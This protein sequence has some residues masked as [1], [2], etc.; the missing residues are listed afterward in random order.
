[1]LIT[2]GALRINNLSLFSQLGAFALNSMPEHWS[3]AISDIITTLQNA[4]ASS[5]QVNSNN[6]STCIFSSLVTIYALQ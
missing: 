1:M 5:S 6:R 3:N 4:A 2:I